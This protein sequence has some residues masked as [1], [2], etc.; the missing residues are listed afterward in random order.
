MVLLD[1][2]RDQARLRHLSSQHQS[3]PRV[4]ETGS[5]S[6]DSVSQPEV[7][8]GRSRALTT[9][10]G[11]RPPRPQCPRGCIERCRVLRLAARSA[12]ALSSQSAAVSRG[13]RGHS[14]RPRPRLSSC[15]AADRPSRKNLDQVPFADGGTTAH[16]ARTRPQLTR[17]LRT[18]PARQPFETPAAG[19]CARTRGDRRRHPRRAPTRT[20]ASAPRGFARS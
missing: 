8:L 17:R 13:S 15:V 2:V 12:S 18:S 3:G 1:T 10:R 9:R 11:R 5:A 16:A 4:Q 20:R 7:D 14:L 6:R 19:P